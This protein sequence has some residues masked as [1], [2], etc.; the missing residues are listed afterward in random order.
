MQHG[1]WSRVSA[2]ASRDRSRAQKAAAALDVPIAYGSYEELLDDPAIEAVYIPLPNHLH[3]PW[4]IRAVEAG[5]HVL[6]EK[7]VALSAVEAATLVDA[8][9]RTGRLIE[10]AFMIRTHPQWL[11]ALA[12]ARAGRIGP[13]RA[14]VGTFSYFNADPANV[15]NVASYGGGALLDIGCYLVNTARMMFGEEPH[16]ACALIDE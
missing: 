12:L 6:C 9:D 3:V 5:K 15:R 1:A 10:E 7:P 11:R 2:L 14:V 16:R 8:R 13:V 4:A